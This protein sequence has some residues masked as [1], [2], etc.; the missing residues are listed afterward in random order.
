ME[1]SKSQIHKTIVNMNVLIK[2]NQKT[3]P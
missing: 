2:S 1:Y 3:I